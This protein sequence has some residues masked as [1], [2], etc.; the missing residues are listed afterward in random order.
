[1]PRKPD[2]LNVREHLAHIQEVIEFY[3]KYGD[4][5]LFKDEIVRIS[6]INKAILRK[7]DEKKAAGNRKDIYVSQKGIQS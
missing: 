3:R 7:H 6:L 1:M 2:Y 5:P 4:C